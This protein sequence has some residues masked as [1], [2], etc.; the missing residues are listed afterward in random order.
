MK[1]RLK[2]EKSE[3]MGNQNE[4]RYIPPEDNTTGGSS[5]SVSNNSFQSFKK[6]TKIENF[7]SE[8]VRDLFHLFLSPCTRF[9]HTFFEPVS[10]YES[11]SPNSVPR[12]VSSWTC[13]F[14]DESDTGIRLVCSET[15][16]FRYA[17]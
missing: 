3:I 15:C 8:C 9:S 7:E 10:E 14:R 12:L 6:S 5:S 17:S 13:L 11:L 1:M 2:T 4:K 16:L